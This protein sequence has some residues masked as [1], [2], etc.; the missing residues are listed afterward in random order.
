MKS[1]TTFWLTDAG[2]FL[3]YEGA[4]VTSFRPRPASCPNVGRGT[5]PNG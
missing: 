3:D 2:E 4:C 5:N 1:K